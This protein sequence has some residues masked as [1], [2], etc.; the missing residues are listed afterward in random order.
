[1][2]KEMGKTKYDQKF[3]LL[4]YFLKEI[5]YQL[6]LTQAEVCEAIGIHVNTLSKIENGNNFTMH[7]FYLLC[8]YYQVKPSEL[9]ALIE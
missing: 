8:H 7:T 6:I 4:G 1:M 9:I 3:E 2:V 5:R